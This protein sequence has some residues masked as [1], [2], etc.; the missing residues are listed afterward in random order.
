[1]PCLLSR[2]WHTSSRLHK[3]EMCSR[4]GAEN[5]P[6]RDPP[7]SPPPQPETQGWAVL[8][9]FC[10]WVAWAQGEGSYCHSWEKCQGKNNAAHQ[11]HVWVQVSSWP[12]GQR[13]LGPHGAHYHEH[14][15]SPHFNWMPSTLPY[16]PPRGGEAA[17]G[18]ARAGEETFREGIRRKLSMPQGRLGITHD[19]FNPVCRVNCSNVLCRD[20]ATRQHPLLGLRQSCYNVYS[21]EHGQKE[22]RVPLWLHSQDQR[23]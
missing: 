2:G 10:P 12:W 3:R 21:S 17:S 6:L 23:Q 5:R 14:S 1:M 4:L 15:Q 7:S 13:V 11:K 22:Q 16:E 18:C 9:E 8:W 20:R 19:P